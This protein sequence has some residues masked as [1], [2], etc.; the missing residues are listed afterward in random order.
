[1]GRELMTCLCLRIGLPACCVEI[2]S[3]VLSNIVLAALK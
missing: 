2:N 3:E 1:M